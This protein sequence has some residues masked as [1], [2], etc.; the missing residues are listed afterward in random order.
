MVI[1]A[2]ELRDNFASFGDIARTAS[3]SVAGRYLAPSEVTFIVEGRVPTF[4]APR[5]ELELAGIAETGVAIDAI[6]LARGGSVGPF[7]V[8]HWNAQDE[9]D[10]V[11]ELGLE[12]RP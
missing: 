4:T 10:G 11:V 12:V 3:G 8:R 5:R 1:S 9:E 6:D 2:D 7:I